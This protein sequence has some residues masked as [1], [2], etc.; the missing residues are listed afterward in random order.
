[1]WIQAVWHQGLWPS[2]KRHAGS[3][4][5]ELFQAVFS[6]YIL[7]PQISLNL[8]NWNNGENG[9]DHENSKYVNKIWEC[10]PKNFTIKYP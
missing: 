9:D 5:A 6:P 3:W 4:E 8:D 7:F 1:M 2:Q 10:N